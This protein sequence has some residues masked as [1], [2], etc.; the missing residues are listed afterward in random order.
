MPGTG[1]TI[2]NGWGTTFVLREGQ[3]IL[4]IRNGWR[5]TGGRR[6]GGGVLGEVV[7]RISGG[8][9]GPHAQ[10]PKKI[11]HVSDGGAGEGESNVR[12]AEGREAE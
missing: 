10:K 8:G 11:G 7:R 6:L 5:P 12:A 1:G 9:G 4:M 2:R 3:V